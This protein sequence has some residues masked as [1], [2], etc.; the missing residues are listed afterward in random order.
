MVKTW[1]PAYLTRNGENLDTDASQKTRTLTHLTRDD[2]NLDDPSSA[3]SLPLGSPPSALNVFCLQN[4]GHSNNLLF[5]VFTNI[6]VEIAGVV[7]VV[8]LIIVVAKVVVV[9][10]VVEVCV[11]GGRMCLIHLTT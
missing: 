3:A 10:V 2:E 4:F 7:V 8:V 9:V 1:T 5:L 6:V 11:G